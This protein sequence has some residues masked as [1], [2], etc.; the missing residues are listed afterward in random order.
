MLHVWGGLG[1]QLQRHAR[2]WVAWG[3]VGGGGSGARVAVALVVFNWSRS[4]GLAWFCLPNRGSVGGVE[5]GG[6][7]VV[8]SVIQREERQRATETLCVSEVAR[9]RRIVGRQRGG[10]SSRGLFFPLPPKVVCV[11]VERQ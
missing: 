9:A 10:A 2:R 11:C 4:L 6:G 5:G 8:A 3:G 1:G 7:A